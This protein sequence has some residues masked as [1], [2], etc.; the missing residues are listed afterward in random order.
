MIRLNLGQ[1]RQIVQESAELSDSEPLEMI[2]IGEWKKMVEV[3][4]PD[5]EEGMFVNPDRTTM[6]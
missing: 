6:Y 4:L 5:R 2:Q 1:L 3:R